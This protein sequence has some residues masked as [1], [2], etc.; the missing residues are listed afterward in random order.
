MRQG[1]DV[2]GDRLRVILKVRKRRGRRWLS[3]VAEWG[4]EQSVVVHDAAQM[5]NLDRKG[6]S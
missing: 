1:F 2:A 5:L 6:P 4:R 3:V